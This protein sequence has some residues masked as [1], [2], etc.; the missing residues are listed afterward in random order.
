LQ[1]SKE[2]LD[3]ANVLFEKGCYG[4]AAYHAQQSIETLFKS[5]AYH[6]LKRY[7]EYA[8]TNLYSHLPLRK[9]FGFLS[10]FVERIERKIAEM[11]R[12]SKGRGQIRSDLKAIVSRSQSMKEAF[13]RIKGFIDKLDS[14]DNF[15]LREDVWKFSMD[16][17]IKTD[18]AIHEIISIANEVGAERSQE[19]F[20]EDM[21]TLAQIVFSDIDSFNRTDTEKAYFR[22]IKP[23]MIK[24]L[25][26]RDYPVVPLTK[27]LDG[28][29]LD[30]MDRAS[31]KE[32]FDL[33]G[34]F[35][36]LSMFFSRTGMLDAVLEIAKQFF[37]NTYE[38]T[39]KYFDLQ[40]VAYATSICATTI[41][42]FPHET[43]GRYPENIM[44]TTTEAIY[45]EKAPKIRHYLDECKR[46]YD[47]IN[48]LI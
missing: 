33:K 27:M 36:A 45:K 21:I 28:K 37:P 6:V 38:L 25:T 46:A 9:V 34:G 2:N 23:F 29:E 32:Y 13:Y 7:P 15:D 35:E 12:A 1:K 44:G 24:F 40:R 3:V 47:H 19:R 18:S 39:A 48:A 41:L 20:M 8:H 16:L 42:L 17:P 14:R 26:D 11:K 5:F 10:N 43:Y 30:R 4:L 31:L 22:K